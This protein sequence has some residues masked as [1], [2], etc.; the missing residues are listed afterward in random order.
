[1]ALSVV[2]FRI[3][4]LRYVWEE[5]LYSVREKVEVR[6]TVSVAVC[7]VLMCCVGWWWKE[8]SR[9]NPVPGHSLFFSKS[10]KGSARF[11]VPIRRTN[12]YQQYYMPCQHTFCGSVC[13]LIQALD[14]NLAIRSCI[15]PS[16]VNLRFKSILINFLTLPDIEPWTCLTTKR[17]K[18]PGIYVEKAYNTV[19]SDSSVGWGR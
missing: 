1:M 5:Y 3:T 19:D 17:F 9:W 6:V 7:V 11:N 16:L 13:Y 8:G 2:Y 14:A 12:R 18:R 10:T 15:S 4:R